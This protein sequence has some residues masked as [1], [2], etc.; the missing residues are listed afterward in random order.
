MENP[1]LEIPGHAR[2]VVQLYETDTRS[3]RQPRGYSRAKIRIRSQAELKRFWRALE[4]LI[5]D[6]DWSDRARQRGAETDT[7][8]LAP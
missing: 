4:N 1:T 2:V 7:A 8:A 5:D 6:R 3:Y